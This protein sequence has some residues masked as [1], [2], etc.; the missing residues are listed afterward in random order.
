[1]E[2]DL[3]DL[4]AGSGKPQSN[5]APR[6]GDANLVR[7]LQR[8]RWSILWERL[9]P[10]LAAIATACGLFLAF[11]WLG[12]WLMLPPLGR[13]IGVGV[14]FLLTAA[15]FAPLLLVRLPKK[16]EALRRLDRNSGLPHRPATT[17]SDD[18]AVDSNDSFAVTLWHTHMER[19]LRA[20]K[21]L[22]AGLPS[23][24][25]ATHDPYAIRGLVAILVVAS[26]F[27]AGSEKFRRIAAAF[28][29]QGV[30]APANYRLDAW[31]SPPTY[32]G[33]PPILLQGLRP[34]EPVQTAAAS[35]SVP[36]G[37]TLVIRASGDVR[38]DVAPTGGVSE[39]KPDKPV[40]AAKGTE[41]HRYAITEDGKVTVHSVVGSDLAWQ[42]T[43]IPDRPPT[44]T[45]TKEPEPQ[46]RGALQLTYKLED[47]YG[48]VGANANFTLKPYEGTN[49]NPPRPLY[50][51][52]DFTLSLPQARTK[53]GVG[54]TS[55]DVTEHPWAGAGVSI[56]L[57]AKDEGGNEGKSEPV[58]LTLPERP[59]SKPTARALIEQRRILALDSEAQ[60]RV[61]N[62]LNAMSMEPEKFKIETNI[63]LGLQSIFWQLASAKSDDQL[64][65][66]VDRMWD[67][68]V[69]L[70]DG[71]VSEAEAALHNAQDAL[72][73]ALE[74]GASD[75][76][77]KK[78]T[79]ELRSAL[80]KFMQALAEQM[81]R[82]PNQQLSRPLDQ[83]QRQ[84]SQQDLR[85]MIDR[86]EQMARNGAR[87]QARRLRRTGRDRPGGPCG[88]SAC[89]RSA[90]R[91]GRHR[92]SGA[93]CRWRISPRESGPS[94]PGRHDPAARGQGRAA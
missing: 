93:C 16:D 45:L 7:A 88:R 89:P 53:N 54:T 29:W 59:F 62:A 5:L 42:F 73:Q 91:S 90:W 84:M 31:V 64:R 9:W 25:L 17:V 69:H 82:N 30:V 13:A 55:K 26:F 49:G 71:S 80:D 78:L 77:I 57:T 66:V 46:T 43:A 20:A 35:V 1:L 92:R 14:F 50:E 48:V 2:S 58:D 67:M 27:A 63:Y 60:A 75:E 51:T 36:A 70:E 18:L 52:P 33:K 94:P 56:T 38:L 86:M 19:A 40:T 81:R 4:I 8:A 37:S 83:N 12:L 23:P 34:G 15:A 10:A 6:K 11:S 79:D 85:S 87:D 72:R 39:T 3:T 47:D 41:E 65:E 44:I 22:R 68:A 74:R 76:E 32:T 28:D 24:R 21:T 61:L